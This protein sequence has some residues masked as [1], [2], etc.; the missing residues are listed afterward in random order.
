MEG[1]SA[2]HIPELPIL[3][4]VM[5]RI[6]LECYQNTK[7]FDMSKNQW[8]F[9]RKAGK[10]GKT[11]APINEPEGVVAPASPPASVL[12]DEQIGAIVDE[13]DACHWVDGECR[14]EGRDMMKLCRALLAASIGG[15]RT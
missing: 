5:G 2:W 12:T 10:L 1:I 11:L 8:N 4:H 15:D 14:I 13:F 9:P 6:L 7:G 3:R